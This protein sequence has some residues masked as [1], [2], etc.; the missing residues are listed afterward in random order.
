MRLISP[1]HTMLRDR[2]SRE[3]AFPLPRFW[4]RPA[5]RV[6]FRGKHGAK[7][8]SVH[9]VCAS[10][11]ERKLCPMSK[12]TVA[13]RHYC[14][15]VGILPASTKT[16]RKPVIMKI[17]I[18]SFTDHRNTLTA[19]ED[20]AYIA[21]GMAYGEALRAAGVFVGGRRDYGHRKLRR[22]SQCATARGM[23]NDGP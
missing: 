9:P 17:R 19:A 15:V 5:L 11:R 16:K 1:A 2:T 8:S 10:P 23:S 14:G 18:Y 12:C 22:P 3:S 13:A 6:L 21:A 20:A 4:L 7:A